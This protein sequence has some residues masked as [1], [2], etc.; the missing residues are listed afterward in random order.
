MPAT[1][2]AVVEFDRWNYANTEELA[3]LAFEESVFFIYQPYS[4]FLCLGFFGPF[5]ARA[6]ESREADN[7]NSSQYTTSYLVN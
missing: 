6:R 5:F 3:Q 4:F 1:P 7:Q 2:A